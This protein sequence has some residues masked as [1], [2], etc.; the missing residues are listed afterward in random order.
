MTDRS[1]FR[2]V[3]AQPRP[4]RWTC[5]GPFRKSWLSPDQAGVLVAA[6]YSNF[7]V[8]CLAMLGIASLDV[9]ICLLASGKWGVDR[10]V[11]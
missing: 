9:F 3:L 2:K 5:S 11:V 1:F 4:G 8:S 6:L 7:P 10:L